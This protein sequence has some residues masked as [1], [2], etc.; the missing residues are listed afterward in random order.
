MNDQGLL[1]RKPYGDLRDVI[2]RRFEDGRV[3]SVGPDDTLLTA[4][5]RMRLADV[6]Q[7]PVLEGGQRLVGVIDESD[8]LLGMQE[9]PS[10]FRL[11]VASAMT[12]TLQTLPPGASMAE[13]RAEL[14]R[15]LV[16]IIADASGFHGLITRVDMLNHLRRSLT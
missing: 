15:G 12:D 16:A 1:A 8:I 5:Q 9:D 11:T 2:A 7:L 10:H 13:L 6:S 4:F 14:D 3:I